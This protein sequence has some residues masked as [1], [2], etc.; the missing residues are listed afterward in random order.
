MQSLCKLVYTCNYKQKERRLKMKKKLIF[1]LLL[2]TILAVAT[3]CNKDTSGGSSTEETAEL[4]VTTAPTN[5]PLPTAAVTITEN[6]DGTSQLNNATAGYNVT[7]DSKSLEMN[8]TDSTISFAPSDKKAKEELNL[9]LA[10][11][12]TTP[13][14]AKQLGKQLKK[15]YKGS[16]KQSETTLGAGKTPADLYT[17]T[18]NKKVT[19]EVYVMSSK[20]KGWYIEMK[21]PSKYKKKYMATFETILGSLEFSE[22]VA[23]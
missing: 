22:T 11:T 16:I 14:S 13:D 21:C 23:E 5:T 8:N 6:S 15:S 17:I 9:F 10:I 12:E 3:A 2:F 7:F 19:H 20:D 4:E 18:D 1:P